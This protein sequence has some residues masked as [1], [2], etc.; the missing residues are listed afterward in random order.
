MAKTLTED[1]LVRGTDNSPCAQVA[2]VAQRARWNPL[3]VS[4]DFFTGCRQ[5]P[6]YYIVAENYERKL[7]CLDCQNIDF[8]DERGQPIWSTTGDGE[9]N[10]LPPNIGVY[11]VRGKFKVESA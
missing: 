1:D 5:H 10:P 11:I 9:M 3:T 7:Y 2:N 4:E 6:I 8:Q